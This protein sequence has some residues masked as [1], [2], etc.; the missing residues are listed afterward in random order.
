MCHADNETWEKR[1]TEAIELSNQVSIKT[2][3]E[4]GNYKCLRTV[5]ADIFKQSEMTEEIR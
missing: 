1:K 5:E 2:L 4:K 3:G